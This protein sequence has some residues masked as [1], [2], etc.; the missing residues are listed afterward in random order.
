MEGGCEERLKTASSL[1]RSM[2]SAGVPCLTLRTMS[3]GTDR[4]LRV[5][6]TLKDVASGHVLFDSASLEIGC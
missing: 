6:V 2:L 3:Q 1:L 5:I 4:G